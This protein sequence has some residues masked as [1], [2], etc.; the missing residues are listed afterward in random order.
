M[1]QPKGNGEELPK[2]ARENRGSSPGG[3]PKQ[4]NKMDDSGR[5]HMPNGFIGKTFKEL[6]LDPKDEAA[7]AAVEG[8]ALRGAAELGMNRKARRALEAQMMPDRRKAS[9]K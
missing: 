1:Q 7:R 5:L 4:E 9:V 6:G 3:E 2:Y 8:A